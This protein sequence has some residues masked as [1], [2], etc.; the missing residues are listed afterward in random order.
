MK[1]LL[2]ALLL[3]ITLIGS[4]QAAGPVTAMTCVKKNSPTFAT[5]GMSTRLATNSGMEILVYTATVGKLDKNGEVTESKN[6][7]QDSNMKIFDSASAA[8]N[9]V[10]TNTVVIPLSDDKGFSTAVLL[11]KVGSKTATLIDTVYETTE[12]LVCEIN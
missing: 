10:G 7:E 12:T 2:A 8:R 6:Y 3:S 5:I 4:V 11:V 1:N 9:W